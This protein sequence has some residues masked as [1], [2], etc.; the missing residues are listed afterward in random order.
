M[1]ER[2]NEDEKKSQLSKTLNKSN[3]LLRPPCSS[4]FHVK[5]GSTHTRRNQTTK[6]N[7]ESTISTEKTLWKLMFI[8][9]GMPVPACALAFDCT[10]YTPTDRS[11]CRNNICQNF[12]RAP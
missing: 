3:V 6:S 8:S 9:T 5:R 1:G 2:N 11:A 12:H 4:G 7:T 10:K